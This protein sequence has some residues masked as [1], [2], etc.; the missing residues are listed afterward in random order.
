MS[1]YQTWGFDSIGA[2]ATQKTP[3][4]DLN[5]GF[6]S[7]Y[8]SRYASKGFPTRY[9][10]EPHV[11]QTGFWKGDDLQ[12]IWHEQKHEDA[13][14]MANAKVHATLLS[15]MRYT[16]TPHGRGTIPKAVLGQ[17]KFANPSFGAYQSSSARQDYSDSPFNFEGDSY[18]SQYQG[19]VLRSA[20]GQEHGMKVLK[21]RIP[22]LDKIEEAKAE[23]DGL[24]AQPSAPLS[25]RQP[26]L[27]Q[28]DVG[29]STEIEL[30]L[31]LQGVLDAL[32]GSDKGETLTSFTYKD[33][34]RALTILFRLVPQRPEI[35]LDD[36]MSK[37]DAILAILNPM[38]SSG[39]PDAPREEQ[40]NIEIATSLLIL[41]TKI[42]DYLVAMEA[43][44]NRSL[45]ERI[46]L[47][48]SLVQSLQF[49]KIMRVGESMATK[50]AGYDWY[51]L[52]Q[53][54]QT[55]LDTRH[56]RN[57]QQEE[58]DNFDAEA[59]GREDAQQR[60]V[61]GPRRGDR[62]G[63]IPDQ[64]QLFGAESGEFYRNGNR[65]EAAYLGEDAEARYPPRGPQPNPIRYPPRG[66]QPRTP[67]RPRRAPPALPGSDI[68]F[69]AF[70]DPDTQGFNVGSGKKMRRKHK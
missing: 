32:L 44:K 8:A 12:A 39:R 20:V 67:G 26:T 16:T 27:Q 25:S 23:M 49:A 21:A 42:R 35:I 22:Q 15:K 61:G 64:R 48:K 33:T 62:R 19:G 47:S 4:T 52:P 10:P 43:G 6:P 37:V 53:A 14:H 69:R 38:V 30:N 18:T 7:V 2:I 58:D 60:E 46:A 57:R 55:Y 29:V 1:G 68:N 56:R 66:P 50:L 65:G 11:P 5:L 41:F 54:R 36:T 3:T 17:R 34:I 31:L 70:Y 24:L 63:F 51:D 13:N 9:M 45:Q 40:G 28:Q 59:E